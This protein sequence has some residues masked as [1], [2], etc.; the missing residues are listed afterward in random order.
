MHIPCLKTFIP[1]QLLCAIC[2]FYDD[3]MGTDPTRGPPIEA[4]DM[5]KS[6]LNEHKTSLYAPGRLGKWPRLIEGQVGILVT[7]MDWVICE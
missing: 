6:D 3:L 7:P 4:E 5:G 1:K 2:E